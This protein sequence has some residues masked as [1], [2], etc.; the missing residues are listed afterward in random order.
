MV[1]IFPVC[2]AEQPELLPRGLGATALITGEVGTQ[3]SLD[4]PGPVARGRETLHEISLDAV[5]DAWAE[6]LARV[7]APLREATPANRGPLPD[8]LRLLD[9]LQLDTVTPAKLSARWDAHAAWASAPPP[10][11]SAPP[12]T[13]CAC[14]TSPTP[15]SPSPPRPGRPAPADRRR[16]RLRQDR[17][18]AHPDR[19]ARRLRAARTPRRHRRRGPGHRGRARRPAPNSRTSRAW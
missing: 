11:C 7:L 9:L 14:S 1:G 4:R 3:L 5:S 16:A 15:S 17:A 13:S 12:A 10:R 18:A 6:R 19:L 8:A 2:L